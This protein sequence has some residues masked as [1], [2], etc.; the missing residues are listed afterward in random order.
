MPAKLDEQPKPGQGANEYTQDMAVRKIHAILEQLR[1][2]I[3]RW[4]CGADTVIEING[5]ILGK[6]ADRSEARIMLEQLEG[7]EH[8]VYTSVALYSGKTQKIDCRT[9][10]SEVHFAP[11]S[12]RE[13]DWYLNTGEW[14]GVS[15]AYKIQG[16]GGCFISSIKGSHSA[17][18]GLPMHEFYDMLVQNGYQ[19]G[20]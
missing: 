11:L 18:V 14:Q 19:Y 4:I 12:E 5:E 13:I 16:L 8:E 9:V 3:P 6:P 1:G 10:K 7:R 17:V 2:R 15:G 20:P